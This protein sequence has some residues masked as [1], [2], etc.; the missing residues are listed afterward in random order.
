MR[1]FIIILFVIL[2]IIAIG[3]YTTKGIVLNKLKLFLIERIESSTNIGLTIK[4]IGFIPVKGI[5]LTGLSLY[6]DRQHKEKTLDITSLYIKFPFRKL[7]ADKIFSPTIALADLTSNN[8]SFNGSFGFSIKLGEKIESPEDFLSAI[9]NIRFRNLSVKN[10]FLSVSNISGAIN[11]SP[12]SIRTADEIT[13]NIKDE[14]CKLL[15]SIINPTDNL[16]LQASLSSSNFNITSNVKTEGELYKIETLKGNLFNSSFNLMGEYGGAE[17]PDLSLF[18]KADLDIKDL[19]H[20]APAESKKAIENLKPEGNL[21]A[22]IYF[23]KNMEKKSLYELGIKVNATYLKVYN[24]RVDDLYADIRVTDGK[25]VIPLIKAFPYNGAFIASLS[26]DLGDTFLPYRADCKLSNMDIGAFLKDTELG[27]KNI[28]GQ[29]YLKFTISGEAKDPSSMAGSASIFIDKANL[30]PMPLLTPLL[31]NLYGY[32]QGMFSGLK[33]IEIT[34]GSCDFDIA[35]RKMTTQN[36]VLWGEVVSI[37]AKG[38]IDFDKNLDFDVK[39]K[40]VEPEE[41][42][43]ESWQTQLQEL[44]VQVGKMMSKARL[45]GTLQKPKWKFQYLGGGVQDIFK[46]QL[47]GVLK[48]IFE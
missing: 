38:Y 20:F 2:L 47:G 3:L 48:G 36:L 39:N 33:R 13:F 27:K 42:E 4:D 29:L 23:K 35:N 14:P 41:T 31:G 26:I 11:V 32:L 34:K 7:I 45:T 10:Q 24:F 1:K 40:F 17:K 15:F 18:G 8:V 12:Q 22:S 43:E 37:H 21:S 28:K 16:S 46:G 5:R 19:A 6:K 30:G 44:I 25:V 9:E